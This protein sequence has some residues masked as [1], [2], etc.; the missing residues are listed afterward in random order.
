MHSEKSGHAI[1]LDLVMAHVDGDW[2]LL[3]E[4]SVMFIEDYPRLLEE[5]KSSITQNDS[6]TVERIAHTLKGRLAFFGMTN[7][8]TQATELEDMGHAND[9]AGAWKALAEMEAALE[10]ILPEFQ[11][12]SREQGK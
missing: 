8:I 5:L 10:V 2:E 7:G 4:L 6:S 3:G 1:N 9:L 11:L 12:L